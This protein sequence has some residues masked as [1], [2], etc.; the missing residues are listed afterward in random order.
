MHFEE[1]EVVERDVVGR[2]LG[3]D[4]RP[5]RGGAG[6]RHGVGFGHRAHERGGIDDAGALDG[7]G[8]E[9]V[10]AEVRG[11]L[12]QAEVHGLVFTHRP[13]RVVRPRDD[14]V[15][16]EDAH[17]AVAPVGHAVLAGDADDAR[18]GI[19]PDRFLEALDCECRG[20]DGT[21]RVA[22]PE[23]DGL[24]GRD[25]HLAIDGERDVSGPVVGVDVGVGEGDACRR[26]VDGIRRRVVHLE[27]LE[28]VVARIVGHDL[29]DHE[30]RDAGSWGGGCGRGSKQAHAQHT[31]SGCGKSSAE[32]PKT[33]RRHR[34]TFGSMG[35]AF[36]T[37]GP[38]STGR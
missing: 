12:R 22:Q 29:G 6:L 33:W 1:L 21:G 30:R 7:V 28:V 35:E 25:G 24:V 2:D 5:V 13:G 32:P 4:E 20:V 15:G 31:H 19:R 18:G 36:R 38:G 27:V 37:Y 26:E 9:H 14:A 34:G 23:H 17:T 11:V 16:A 8:C 3:D 10:E